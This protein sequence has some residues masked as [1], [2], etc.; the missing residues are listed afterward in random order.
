MHVGI[1]IY[2]V[3]FT[4]LAFQVKKQIELV[5]SAWG[6]MYEKVELIAVLLVENDVR[7]IESHGASMLPLYDKMPLDAISWKVFELHRTPSVVPDPEAV[8]KLTRDEMRLA[9]Y[10]DRMSEIDV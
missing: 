8:A 3:A 2:F 9:G 10:P 6:M 5:F 1:V 4:G 7:G